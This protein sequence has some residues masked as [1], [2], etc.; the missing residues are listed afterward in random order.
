VANKVTVKI[1][2]KLP[3]GKW[4]FLEPVFTPT[5]RLKPFFA[6]VNGRSECHRE[7][8]YY[9]RFRPFGGRRQTWECVG[10]NPELV[11]RERKR[12]SASLEL[13][14]SGIQ[15]VEPS[16][17]NKRS[18]V[19]AISE[20][21]AEVSAQKSPR[22]ANVYG[23]A[24]ARFQKSCKKR[25][26]GDVARS[27]I[28][29]FI[30]FL[31]KEGL[32]DRTVHNGVERI[33]TFLRWCGI[34]GL[35]SRNDKPKFT[36]K[37]VDAYDENQLEALYVHSTREEKLLWQFFVHTGMRE[38]EVAHVYYTDVNHNSKVKTVSVT[39]KPE[40]GWKPKDKE[41]R[42]A[43]I[44]DWLAGAIAER[45]KQHPKDKLIF[46]NAY[47]RPGGH[48]LKK[49]KKAAKR[50]GLE[51]SIELHK[52]RKTAATTWMRKGVDVRTIQ[53]WL[54]HGDLETTEAYLKPAGIQEERTW[55]LI[56]EA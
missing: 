26:L 47:G 49:L 28:M 2:A 25:N 17:Q 30:A 21:K 18:L 7:A 6:I 41:E 33:L 44:P 46:P 31:R 13:K 50:A 34:T 23:Y 42:E 15:V 51:C 22:T 14:R 32:A 20:Y 45:R 37:K 27:D 4:H 24:L 8:N 56:N 54:G 9:L 16:D 40:W 11:L 53:R 43:P 29:D 52:F 39:E 3:D 10:K 5:G 12:K 38:G 48:L 19:S 1:R 36:A 55:R 35:L